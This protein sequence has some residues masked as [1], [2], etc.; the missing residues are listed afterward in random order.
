MEKSSKNRDSSQLVEGKKS[1]KPGGDLPVARRN[2]TKRARKDSV[3]TVERENRQTVP[4]QR[5][6]TDEEIAAK[7][8]LQRRN[9]LAQKPVFLKDA[10]PTEPQENRSQ[11]PSKERRQ[12]RLVKESPQCHEVRRNGVFTSKENATDDRTALRVLRK[13]F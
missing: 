3:K 1:C 8:T 2:I 11:S 7:S 5:K 10:N 13:K 4:K 12:G 9:A 6:E